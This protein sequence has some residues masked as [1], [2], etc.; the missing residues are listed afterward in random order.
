M[1]GIGRVWDEDR[2]RLFPV[3][4]TRTLSLAGLLDIVRD[5][6]PRTDNVVEVCGSG[7]EAL[8]E[9]NGGVCVRAH[10][11]CGADI[12][13]VRLRARR[14][15]DAITERSQPVIF[16]LFLLSSDTRWSGDILRRRSQPSALTPRSDDSRF[17]EF[18]TSTER[19]STSEK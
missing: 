3:G 14:N 19:Q 4:E 12:L 18:T 10:G 15:R 7:G 2:G 11:K 1:G 9:W 16:L 13:L 5:R 8:G 6:F 17:R